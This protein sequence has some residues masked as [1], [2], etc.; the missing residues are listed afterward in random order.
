MNLGESSQL[1]DRGGLRTTW[2]RH[3]D[4]HDFT[5]CNRP[6]VLD[7]NLDLKFTFV[8]DR[9]DGEIRELEGSVGKTVT[10]GEQGLDAGFVEETVADIDTLQ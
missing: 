7:G 2:V 10:K 9:G 4:L 3:I 1:L 6:S 8:R 5:S